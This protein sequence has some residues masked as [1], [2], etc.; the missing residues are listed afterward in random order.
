MEVKLAFLLLVCNAHPAAVTRT[1]LGAAGIH[2]A[3]S[4]P[5][6]ASGSTTAAG[7]PE[8]R[9]T[10]DGQRSPG[11]VQ[12]RQELQTDDGSVLADPQPESQTGSSLHT[13]APAGEAMS[14]L[15]VV[16]VV[17]ARKQQQQQEQ[18]EQQ[19]EWRQQQEQEER[20]RQE[21]REE[22]EKHEAVALVSSPHRDIPTVVPVHAPA[23][24]ATFSGAAST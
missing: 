12:E 10:P 18:Q 1:R 22:D 17:R 11:P 15:D 2:A 19:E 9:V 24:I 16:A 21:E 4:R 23:S 6:S 5:H 3:P 20:H 7:S 14:P 13:L 8:P